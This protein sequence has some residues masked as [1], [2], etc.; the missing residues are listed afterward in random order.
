MQPDKNH[1][2]VRTKLIAYGICMDNFGQ[3]LTHTLGTIYYDKNFYNIR[4]RGAWEQQL[5]IKN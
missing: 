2:G 4:S 3:Y 5:N 1:F